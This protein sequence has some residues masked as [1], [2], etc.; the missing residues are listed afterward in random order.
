MR[1]IHQ[2]QQ[3]RYIQTFLTEAS[4]WSLVSILFQLQ[5]KNQF[6]LAISNNLRQVFDQ[7]VVVVQPVLKDVPGQMICPTCQNTVITEV[8]HINGL[9]TWLICAFS[10]LFLLTSFDAQLTDI[11]DKSHVYPPD[12]TASPYPPPPQEVYQAEPGLQPGYQSGFQPGLQPGFQPGKN[13]LGCQCGAGV[14]KVTQL[15][16]QLTAKDTEVQSLQDQIGSLTQKLDETKQE[17][18]HSERSWQ[19]K[20]VLRG[21]CLAEQA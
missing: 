16:L 18:I 2:K 15:E 12:G 3:P 8:K 6:K 17:F 19:D 21:G 1:D 7:V 11:M 20:N 13:Q 5:V 10:G 4:R 14:G 9:L